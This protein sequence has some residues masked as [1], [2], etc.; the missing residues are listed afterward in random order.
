[1]NKLLA[2]GTFAAVAG[3][4]LWSASPA[5]TAPGEKAAIALFKSLTEE[6]KKLALHPVDAKER[7]K[8]DFPEVKR[9]G[10]PYALLSA[11]QKK[12]VEDAVRAVTSDYGAERLLELAKQTGDKGRYLNFFGEPGDGKA[13]AW[14]VAMH[15]LTLV[16]AE[17]G[18]Q[19][20]EEFG[21][22]LLGGNPVKTL[23][24]GEDQI[25]LK[26]YAALTPEELG[27]AK[28]KAPGG[29][30]LGNLNEKA[31]ELARSLLA[32]RLEV[33]N[34]EYRKIFQAQ[35]EREG[36]ADKLRLTIQGD[37]SKSHHEGGNYTWAIV[38]QNLLCN[39]QTAGKEH[40]H[41]TLR[42][43]KK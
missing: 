20:A 21:P 26:L 42:A 22:I 8:E 27:K 33:F 10:L 43:R 28:G 7:Y 37:G 15:H 31:R 29:A 19:K 32:K 40:I 35:V 16:Y 38:G 3:L 11:E 12:M 30:N 25:F 17:F 39:W 41:M 6:Q 13:F 34:P 24:D 9:P 14:R 23:W 36:G 18:E 5:Q 4:A 2:M 1:M